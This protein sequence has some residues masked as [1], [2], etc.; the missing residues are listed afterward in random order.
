ME[1]KVEQFDY[2]IALQQLKELNED[3]TGVDIV[4]FHDLCK[5]FTKLSGSLGTLIS[6]GFEGIL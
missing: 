3:Q 6:W 1:K 4:K 2:K 5:N